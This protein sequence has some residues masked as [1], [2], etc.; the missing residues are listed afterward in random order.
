[1]IGFGINGD[2]EAFDPDAL[3]FFNIFELVSRNKSI[4]YLYP[5]VDTPL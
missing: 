4:I 3:K 2:L 5:Y 1:M